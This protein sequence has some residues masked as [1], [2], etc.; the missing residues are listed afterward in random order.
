MSEGVEYRR[1]CA[2]TDECDVRKCTR[3]WP[4]KCSWEL[5]YTYTAR[6]TI[7]MT[8]YVLG[9]H[10][11]PAPPQ[12]TCSGGRPI[13]PTAM[14]ERAT[15]RFESPAATRNA[16]ISAEWRRRRKYGSSSR[17]PQL[18]LK[19]LVCKPW[20]LSVSV[21]EKKGSQLKQDASVFTEVGTDT[22]K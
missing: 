18:F 19:H 11:C 17:M 22:C 4:R 13:A 20:D 12:T 6:R 14:W 9:I 15:G 16:A 5:T 21:M 1:R 10:N 8:H 7:H 2:S 3:K